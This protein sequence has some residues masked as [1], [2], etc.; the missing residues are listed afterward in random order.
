MKMKLDEIALFHIRLQLQHPFETSFTRLTHYEAIVVRVKAG[1]VE[2]YGE[3]PVWSGPWYSA[4]DVH[5]AWHAIHDLLA[6]AALSAEIAAPSDM[7]S[8]FHFV[9]GHPMAKAAIE[10]ALWDA[11]AKSTGRSL[12]SMFGGD[13]KT[14]PTGISLGMEASTDW[15]LARVG[16][17]VDSGYQRVK[18]KIKPGRDVEPLRQ[19]RAAFPKLAMMADANAAYVL[20][21]APKLAA[22]DDLAL[23]MIEQ[24]LAEDDVL[25]HSHLA[26]KIKTPIC[27][28]ES[29]SS[30]AHARQ[31]IEI[32]AC[33][34]VNVKQARVG[35]ATR[36]IELHELCRARNVPVWCGGLLESGIGRLHN[37]ALASLPGFTLPG[38]VSASERY[39]AEDLVDPPVTMARDGTIEVPSA[40]GIGHTVLVDRLEKSSVRRAT[41]R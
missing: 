38:D 28:D 34:I 17:A 39:Y 10:G 8:R 36:A 25:D 35:G 40:P 19:V 37:V 9:R 2:G 12:S 26:R 1:S 18:I 7:T 6:P 27:L 22:L 4:E 32:G 13:R 24:P 14:I 41:V 5:T 31:A 21:D 11:F 15:L 33:A 16:K 20:G 23:T 29:I 30:T 3:A